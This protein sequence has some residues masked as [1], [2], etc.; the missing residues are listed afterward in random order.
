MV[1]LAGLLLFLSF[2]FR[3]TVCILKLSSGVVLETATQGCNNGECLTSAQ[4]KPCNTLETVV[5]RIMDALNS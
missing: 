5:E 3:D 4:L 1:L 2:L